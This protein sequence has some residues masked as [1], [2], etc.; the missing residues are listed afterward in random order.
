MASSKSQIHEGETLLTPPNST[1]KPGRP[2]ILARFNLRWVSVLTVVSIVFLLAC[3]P[4]RNAADSK[5]EYC[6]QVD[7][8]LPKERPDITEQYYEGLLKNNS[9]WRLEAAERLA[10]AVRI[11]TETFDFLRDVPPPADGPDAPERDGLVKFREWLH[12]AFPLVHE[13]LSLEVINRYA[14]LYTWQGSE[15][16]AKPLVL[17]SHIDTVPV[18]ASS[19]DQWAHPPFSGHVDGEYVWGRGSVDTKS[20]LVSIMEAVNTLLLAGMETKRTVIL[21]FG[22]DEEISGYHGAK[23]LAQALL[24]RGLKDKVELLVDEGPD[25]FSKNGATIAQIG[26]SEKGYADVDITVK[27]PGGHSSIPPTHT[28]IG[29]MSRIIANLEDHPYEPVLG[30]E[31]PFLELLRCEAR[32][33]PKMSRWL[34]EAINKVKV[35]RPA[36]VRY[37]SGFPQL[38]YMMATSQA[39]D[40]INGG[41]KLNALPEEVT[42]SI[43]NRIAVHMNV[44][45]VEAEIRKHVLE[46]ISGMGLEF[47]FTD[48]NG[49]NWTAESCSHSSKKEDWQGTIHVATYRG[50]L[51]PAPI[52]PFKNDRAWDLLSGTVRHVS[53]H[54][55]TRKDTQ[56]VLSEEP[57]N[58]E[59]IV[60]PVLMA[61]NTDTRHYWDLTRNIYRYDPLRSNKIFGVHTVNEHIAIDSY[62]EAVGFFH[63]LIRNFQEL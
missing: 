55:W 12:E 10:Q 23:Y 40:M 24:D 43:N 58:T 44:T 52:S 50:A 25:I 2:P 6:Q 63:E 5:S 31:N 11:N 33:A 14:L 56:A 1:R 7:P 32:F 13:K 57:I 37:L 39:A 49:R 29:I 19:L 45:L 34:R 42:A 26:V 48:H 21:A 47:I 59:I 60:A 46:A 8:L 27:T 61:A 36:L 35:F 15:S 53:S 28:G 38:R 30:D 54:D 62:A 4:F 3:H 20:T 41:V 16:D 51:E 22:F 9:Q 18:A 17:C